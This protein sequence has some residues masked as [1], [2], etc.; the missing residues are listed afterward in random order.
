MKLF[1]VIGLGRFGS[2]VAEE[3]TAQ[4]HQVLAIDSDAA[5][6]QRM[7]DKVTQAVSGDC[8]DMEVLRALG[9]KNADCAVVAFGN[10]I[11]TAAL[12]A[13]NLKELGIPRLICKAGNHREQELLHRIGADEVIF[14][15]HETG[16]ALAHTLANREILDY[17]EL[18]ERYGIVKL[19]IPPTWQGKTLN[20]LDIR[21]KYQVNIIAIQSTDGTIQTVPQPSYLFRSGDVVFTLGSNQDNERMTSLGAYGL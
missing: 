10:D 18:S 4:G 9:V 5:A 7:A 12:I 14:P 11:G 20:E 21:A 6:V 13:L 19:K 1:V 17:I 15:E 2:A 3:L 16:K 8:Q